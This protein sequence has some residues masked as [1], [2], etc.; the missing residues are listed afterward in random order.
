MK[1]RVV[2]TGL[3][4][5]SSIGIGKDEFWSNL[6]KGKSGI[7]K[8]EAFD[9]S[10]YS[11]KYG[12]GIKKFKPEVLIDKRKKGLLGRVSLLAINATQLALKD[13]SLLE[14]LNKIKDSLGVAIGTTM[15]ETVNIEQ[16]SEERR[17]GKECR[18]RWSPYH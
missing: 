11:I 16:R 3:G 7:S 13:G 9:I 5:V 4:I 2:I 8:I 15:G 12:G 18:S 10:N 17:V 1:R 6:I 14:S